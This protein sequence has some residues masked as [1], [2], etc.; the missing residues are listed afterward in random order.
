MF[1]YEIACQLNHR[2]RC[3]LFAITMPV[4]PETCELVGNMGVMHITVNL[5]T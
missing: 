3:S 4:D 5:I 2:C 1:T